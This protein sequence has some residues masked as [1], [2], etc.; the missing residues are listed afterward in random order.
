[1]NRNKSQ[2]R[3]NLKTFHLLWFRFND[4]VTLLKNCWLEYWVQLLFNFTLVNVCQV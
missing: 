2:N 1:M 4:M 3:H